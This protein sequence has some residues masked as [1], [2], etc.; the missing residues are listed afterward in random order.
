MNNTPGGRQLPG[1]HNVKSDQDE[2]VTNG[3][4]DIESDVHHERGL[5]P[6]K[7][8]KQAPQGQGDSPAPNMISEYFLNRPIE[9]KTVDA[10]GNQNSQAP[11]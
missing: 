2:K 5:Q 3:E 10:G 8:Q 11:S 9:I 7:R 6:V 1:P 4:Q